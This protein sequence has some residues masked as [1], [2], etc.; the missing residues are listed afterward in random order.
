MKFWYFPIGGGQTIITVSDDGIGIPADKRERIFRRFDRL[1]IDS[2]KISGSGIGLNYSYELAILHKGQLT[3][4]PKDTGGSVF[5]FSFPTSKE[6]YT[7]DQIDETYCSKTYVPVSVKSDN[8]DSAK[9]GTILV[10]EDTSDLRSYLHS[11][12][13]ENYN[14]VTAS[15]GFEALDSIKL[16]MPDLVISDILMPGKNGYELC[17]E[18]KTTDE[19][20]HL[21]VILLTAKTD[22]HST[23]QGYMTGADAYVAKPFDPDY[24]KAVVESQLRNRRILQQKALNLTSEVVKAD[25]DA[26]DGAQLTPRDKFLLEKIHTIMEKNLS[27]ERFG[28]ED[29]AQALDMSYSSLYAKMKAITGKTPLFFI[30]N[31]RMNRAKEMLESKLYTVS[32]VA[33]KVGSLLP[34]TFSRD[35]KKHFGVTP[36]SLLK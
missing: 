15:D 12:F 18:I 3:Y 30:N 1:D 26:A 16:G 14:V 7:P 5:S 32:E 21:P 6:S 27:N 10:V 24:L 2:V 34:N 25:P 29:M 22:A 23:I 35:F 36:S 19:W 20:N 9:R 13:S 4:Q 8:N 31:Y 28:V 17:N 33:F 11:L